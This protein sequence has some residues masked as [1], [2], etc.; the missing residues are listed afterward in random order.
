MHGNVGLIEPKG[1]GGG[2]VGSRLQT[3]GRGAGSCRGAAV[4]DTVVGLDTGVD[5]GGGAR[6]PGLTPTMPARSSRTGG[7]VPG[8]T[9]STG[10][11]HQSPLWLG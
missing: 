2:G 10:L 11:I 3:V 4:V 5:G 8:V 6:G 7:T 9:G 1:L